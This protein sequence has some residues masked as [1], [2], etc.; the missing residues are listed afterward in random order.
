MRQRIGL[1]RGFVCPL[2][3]LERAEAIV[4]WG[5]A[6]SRTVCWAHSWQRTFCRI[7][8]PEIQPLPTE[9]L[10]EAKLRQPI[11]ALL[12]FLPA[13]DIETLVPNVV[14]GNSSLDASKYNF[15][16]QFY[17]A[18]QRALPRASLKNE[19][20]TKGAMMG[21]RGRLDFIVQP[22]PGEDQKIWWGYELLV[23]GTQEALMENKGRF[24]KGGKYN[25]QLEWDD[26]LLLDCHTAPIVKAGV[27]KSEKVATISPHT[28]EG[29]NVIVLDHRGKRVNIP[30]DGV[31]RYVAD[32][33]HP[34]V[35]VAVKL[36]ET[37]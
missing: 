32:W 17:G 34:E 3:D 25:K 26:Y 18:V 10:T 5:K 33:S 6:E 27:C 31:P 14:T 2:R 13:F 7:C 9:S 37:A 11:D 15:Q 29:W 4:P 36:V 1:R 24:A 30:R 28:S 22:K 19:V 8:E 23:R 16:A 21:Q 20:P 12:R 35:K